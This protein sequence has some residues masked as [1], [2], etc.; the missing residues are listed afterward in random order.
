MAS[1]EDVKE[2]KNL[3]WD[4]IINKIHGNWKHFQIIQEETALVRQVRVDVELLNKEM[5]EKP[6]KAKTLITYWNALTKEELSEIGIP[7]RTT[8]MTLA[9]Q[10]LIKRRL[11]RSAH[12]K[13]ELLVNNIRG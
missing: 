13:K 5:E 9:N 2:A 3:L 8:T 10:V 11:T 6:A 1:Y 12:N 7:D 4:N